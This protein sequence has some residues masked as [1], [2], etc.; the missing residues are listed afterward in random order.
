MN[1][2]KDRA[3]EYR[4]RMDRRERLRDSWTL[5]AVTIIVILLNAFNIIP[6]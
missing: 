3:R 2:I 6:L 5:V 1:E 4:A